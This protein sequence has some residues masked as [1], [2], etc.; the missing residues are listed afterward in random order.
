MSK[1]AV[2]SIPA[3]A[4]AVDPSLDGEFVSISGRLTSSEQLGD[5]PYL[6]PGS[7]IKL[8]REV[9]MYAWVEKSKGQP[10]ASAGGS[11]S[12]AEHTYQRTWTAS[13]ADSSGFE[14]SWGHENPTMSIE[15]AS[16]TVSAASIGAYRVDPKRILLPS[17]EDLRLT[18]SNV[19]TEGAGQGQGGY[20]HVEVTQPGGT[21]IEVTAIDATAGGGPVL[22]GSYIFIG[23]GSMQAP[24]VGDV[25]IRYK[26]VRDDLDVTAFG[27]IE[28]DRIVPYLHRGRHRL[29]AAY[30][31]DRESA[32]VSMA[33][34]YRASLWA[35][36]VFGFLMMWGGLSLLLAPVTSVLGIVPILGRLS[37]KAIALLTFLISLVL[38]T[39]MII[40][41]AIAHSIWALVI[42]VIVVGVL[43]FLRFQRMQA[44]KPAT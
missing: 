4:N 13:P 16:F 6:K 15:K 2:K 38:S 1:V 20:V 35:F 36:R 27:K 37:G 8:T 29:Y 23:R 22:A 31:A 11:T 24:R 30:A 14:V 7:Y 44:T 26:H 5:E 19:N 12:T 21:E 17:E 39:A 41:S 42:V 34:A 3:R 28:G 43:A 9:E 18:S 33:A 32:I 10:P 25:R 40:I